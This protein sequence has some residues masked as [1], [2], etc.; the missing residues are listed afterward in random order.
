MDQNI[1]RPLI[2][3]FLCAFTRPYDDLILNRRRGKPPR[4]FKNPLV[5]LKY[6]LTPLSAYEKQGRARRS[7]F[8]SGE[9]GYSA[10]QSTKPQTLGYG[11]ADSPVGLLSWIYEKLVAWTDHYPWTDDEGMFRAL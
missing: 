8:F 3:T 1:A 6:N 10:E 7:W 2:Q 11:L 4:F 9:Q 5:Y